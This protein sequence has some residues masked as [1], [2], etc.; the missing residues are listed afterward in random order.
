[1]KWVLI[2][3]GRDCLSACGYTPKPLKPYKSAWKAIGV[4]TQTQTQTHAHTDTRAHRHTDTQTQTHA[5]T[6]TQTHRHTDTDRRTHTLSHSTTNKTELCLGTG[7]IPFPL[8]EGSHGEG[9]WG[10]HIDPPFLVF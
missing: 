7:N 4:L 9:R 1:M 6:D 5:H 10:I 2:S 3:S 8:V